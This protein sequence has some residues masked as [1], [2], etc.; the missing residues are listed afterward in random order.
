MPKFQVFDE[1]EENDVKKMLNCFQANTLHF[2]K[3]TTILSNIAATTQIGVI[4]SGGANVIRYNYNGSRTIMEK[5]VAGDIFGV[6]YSSF[7]ED[8]YIISTEESEIIMFDYAHLINRCKKN[9]EY[10]NK[11]IDN[12]L[13]ILNEKIKNYNE[14]IEVLTEK[15]IRDKLLKYF[16]S[17]SKKQISKSINLP[18]SLTDLADYLSID[19]SAM[20]REIRN[21]NDEGIIISKGKKIYL[22]Y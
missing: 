8:L 13:Q 21:L 1:I 12:M 7:S 3:D 4:I 16:N 14:R 5:L 15:T 10:H 17:I 11:L 18:F 6:F 2:K 20:M 22:N 19:R 9:C